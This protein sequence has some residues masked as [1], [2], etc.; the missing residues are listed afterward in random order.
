MYVCVCCI[1]REKG[2]VFLNFSFYGQ[3]QLPLIFSCVHK[4]SCWL[5]AVNS[6]QVLTGAGEGC[7]QQGPVKGVVNKGW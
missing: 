1:R 5:E 4:L 6:D 3:Y 2:V 7:G